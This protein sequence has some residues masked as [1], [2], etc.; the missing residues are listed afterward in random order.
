M[1]EGHTW[2]TSRVVHPENLLQKKTIFLWISN[3]GREHGCLIGSAAV[4]VLDHDS[5]A[6]AA[7]NLMRFSRM[8]RAVSAHPA[9]P[10]AK[11][12]KLMDLSTGTGPCWKN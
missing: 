11:A 1:A 4:V 5:I 10:D 7:L 3:P 12:V 2:V 6:D 8:N 9:A